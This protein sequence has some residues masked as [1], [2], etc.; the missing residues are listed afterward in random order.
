MLALVGHPLGFG[1]EISPLRP[2]K[3]SLLVPFGWGTI[4]SLLWIR[5]SSG[6]SAPRRCIDARAFCPSFVARE[7]CFSSAV[8]DV[9]VANAAVWNN[10][11]LRGS[12]TWPTATS[13]AEPRAFHAP[14]R[15][16]D[17]PQKHDR[18]A[19]KGRPISFSHFTFSRIA[20]QC[21][22]VSGVPDRAA[23]IPAGQVPPSGQRP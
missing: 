21:A 15:E 8:G 13:P 12:A 23:A 16:V 7:G 4:Q 17:A 5:S 11:V 18:P 6:A 2:R 10:P 22:D 3:N 1:V 19:R 20:G 14:G 9:A